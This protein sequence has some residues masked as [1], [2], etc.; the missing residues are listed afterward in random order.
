MEEK[1]EEE[2]EEADS[3]ESD[4]GKGFNILACNAPLCAVWSFESFRFF[5]VELDTEGTIPPDDDF[6]HELGDPS[7]EVTEEMR[8]KAQEER[9]EG[10]MAFSEG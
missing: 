1:E 10:S 9:M 5:F 7:I 2:K 3:P 8:E 4:L 6:S